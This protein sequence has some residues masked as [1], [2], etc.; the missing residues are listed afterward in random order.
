MGN[1]ATMES[2]PIETS[3]SQ[4]KF[5]NDFQFSKY[6]RPVY[7]NNFTRNKM[8]SAERYSRNGSWRRN[9]I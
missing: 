6:R 9:G 7:Q 2:S 3:I 4:K 5:C 1:L 8:R